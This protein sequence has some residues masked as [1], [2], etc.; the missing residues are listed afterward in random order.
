[1]EKNR[2]FLPLSALS[3][4]HDI[5]FPLFQLTPVSRPSSCL[6][7]RRWSAW[8]SHCRCELPEPPAGNWPVC[9]PPGGGRGPASSGSPLRSP[10]LGDAWSPTL[11]PEESNRGPGVASSPSQAEGEERRAH[12]AVHTGHATVRGTHRGPSDSKFLSWDG[13]SKVHAL[14]PRRGLGSR[15]ASLPQKST[16]GRGMAHI[17]GLGCPGRGATHSHGP[18]ACFPPLLLQTQ[19]LWKPVALPAREKIQSINYPPS[20]TEHVF[21][22]SSEGAQRSGQS[23]ATLITAS[24]PWHVG[25]GGQSHVIHRR[26]FP[27]PA[28]QEGKNPFKCLQHP[29]P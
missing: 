25:L 14:S 22:S 23:T 6:G 26:K 24:V 21:C 17:P 18:H 27:R 13:N 3:S 19:Q 8:A 20:T 10:G 1:M 7:S 29:A 15:W 28:C 4:T 16:Q 11:Q 2:S 12:W 5:F 9:L